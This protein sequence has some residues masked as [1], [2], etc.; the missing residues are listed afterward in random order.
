M[1][2]TNSSLMNNLRWRYTPIVVRKEGV[3]WLDVGKPNDEWRKY[4]GFEVMETSVY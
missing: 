1:K 2:H 3:M 4:G